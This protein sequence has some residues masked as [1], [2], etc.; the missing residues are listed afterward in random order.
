MADLLEALV[1]GFNGLFVRYR[2]VVEHSVI[3][4]DPEASAILFGDAEDRELYLLFAFSIISA[5]IQPTTVSLMSLSWSKDR[6]NC[7]FVS[8]FVLAD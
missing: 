8:R 6:R 1:D 4:D 7:L 2:F 5:L 3:E